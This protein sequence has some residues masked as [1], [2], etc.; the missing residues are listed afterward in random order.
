MVQC[1]DVSIEDQDTELALQTISV[2]DDTFSR[3]QAKAYELGILTEE[4][5]S[6]GVAYGLDNLLAV[7]DRQVILPTQY[8]FS[9]QSIAFD[10]YQFK[11]P[12]NPKSVL[13]LY[14]QNWPY[15]PQDILGHDHFSKVLLR[16]DKTRN[17]L[18]RYLAS[19]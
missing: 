6:K 14:F 1:S 11:A 7:A 13:D 2:I 3:Y 18:I 4:S 17:A 12:A 5:K 19:D 8:V 16:D 15:L 10:R 9:L